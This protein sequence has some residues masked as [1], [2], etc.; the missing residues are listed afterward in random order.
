MLR[1]FGLRSM[2]E[3]LW[4]C[5]TGFCGAAEGPGAGLWGAGGLPGPGKPRPL[6]WSLRAGEMPGSGLVQDVLQ[7]PH[8]THSTPGQKPWIQILGLPPQPRASPWSQGELKA[9]SPSKHQHPNLTSETCKS[10]RSFQSPQFPPSSHRGQAAAAFIL[11]SSSPHPPALSAAPETISQSICC[12][13]GS[14]LPSQLCNHNPLI[15]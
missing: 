13:L 2:A 9:P 12:C 7:L 11:P 14:M 15:L 8:L 5:G 1:G 3:R 10:P 4:Q 6:P